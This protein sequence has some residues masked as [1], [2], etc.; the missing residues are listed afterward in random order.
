MG[1]S[2][3]ATHGETTEPDSLENLLRSGTKRTSPGPAV[4]DAP[5]QA[6]LLALLQLERLAQQATRR[7]YE[8]LRKQYE[9]YDSRFLCLAFV[10]RANKPVELHQWL[11]SVAQNTHRVVSSSSL[12]LLFGCNRLKEE[13]EW[14]DSGHGD[15]LADVSSELISDRDRDSDSVHMRPTVALKSWSWRSTTPR[16]ETRGT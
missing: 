10:T 11:R 13:L 4:T 2:S 3:P 8:L 15:D 12:S 1:S 7:D 14:R 16:Y 9:R 6:D 5:S